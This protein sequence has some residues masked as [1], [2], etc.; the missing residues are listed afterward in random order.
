MNHALPLV[1]SFSASDPTAGAGLQ[2]DLLTVAALGAHPLTIVTGLTAQNTQGVSR[3]EPCPVDWVQAQLDCLLVDEPQIKAVKAGV[4]GS[5]EVVELLARWKAGVPEIPLVLD[6]VMASGRGDALGGKPVFAAM[7]KQL[8]PHVALLTP[9]WPEARA[10][11]GKRSAATAAKAFLDLGCK[12]VLIKGEH[13]ETE[14]VINRLY[15]QGGEVLEFPCERL[16]HQYHGSGCTLA[17]AC[18]TALAQGLPLPEAVELA[19]SYTWSSLQ[20][21][22]PIGK[23]QWIPDRLHMMQELNALLNPQGLAA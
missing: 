15:L 8:F 9:N 16:P 23:G 4:L 19:L 12:A 20:H 14:Q 22:F 3:F 21:A 7:K 18:A 2:A 11:T 10:L 1:L 13:A 5:V 6:P 17:S